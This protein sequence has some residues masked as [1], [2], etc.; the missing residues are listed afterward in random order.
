MHNATEGAAPPLFEVV[1][2]DGHTFHIWPNGQAEGFPEGSALINGLAPR[3][4]LTL[5][6]VA[7]ARNSGRITEQEAAKILRTWEGAC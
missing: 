1:T 3:V 4:A 6:I 5:G 2:P 7:H